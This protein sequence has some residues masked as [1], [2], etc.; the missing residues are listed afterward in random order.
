MG[1]V[2]FCKGGRRVGEHVVGW[3]DTLAERLECFSSRGLGQTGAPGLRGCEGQL[4][5]PPGPGHFP[6]D[7]VLLLLTFP[8]V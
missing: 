3:T 8:R 6:A 5:V 2:N 1:S 4:P 7:A